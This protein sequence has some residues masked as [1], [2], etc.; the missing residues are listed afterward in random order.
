VLDARLLRRLVQIDGLIQ[1]GRNRFFAV[2]VLAG[3]DRLRQE[4]RP[5]L[6]R[7]SIEEDR[8]LLVPQR[9]VQVRGPALDAMLP[10]QCLH[11]RRIASDEQRIGD[12][13][14]AVLQ[15]H[16]AL[17]ADL[18]DRADEVLV[19]PH[20]AGNAVHDDADALLVHGMA[21][22]APQSGVARLA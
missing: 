6:R 13:A 22:I 20:A 2:H 11:L 18:E 3:L 7:G 12:N 17:L 21:L 8:V 19:H 4:L 16:S 10:S 5:Q 15:R 1:G 9:L 14:R